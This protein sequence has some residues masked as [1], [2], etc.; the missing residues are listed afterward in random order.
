MDRVAGFCQV[1]GPATPLLIHGIDILNADFMN[2]VRA[3]C[4]NPLVAL[5]TL[6]HGATV[7]AFADAG[8]EYLVIPN[9][10]TL[11]RIHDAAC[12]VAGVLEGL[13][14]TDGG[15]GDLSPLL[16]EVR[17]GLAR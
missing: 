5:S 17:V 16:A 3:I 4:S 2:Q 1:V 7:R 14:C 11:R 6:S 8:I 13:L 15:Y 9:L 10:L 12:L